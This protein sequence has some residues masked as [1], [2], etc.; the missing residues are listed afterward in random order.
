[1][2]RKIFV[3]R[4]KQLDSVRFF[5]IAII[6]LSHFEFLSNTIIGD[7]YFRYLKNPLMGVDYFFLLSGFG[8]FYTSQNKDFGIKFKDN[9][10][11]AIGKI[12]KIYGLYV[13]SLLISIPYNVF[14]T[15][16]G[17]NEVCWFLST[18][19]ICYIFVPPVI[20]FLK[21]YVNTKR[22]AFISLIINSVLIILIYSLFVK[23]ESSIVIKGINIIDDLSYGSPYFRI[24]YLIQGLNIA[25]LY[26]LVKHKF[27]NANMNIFECILFGFIILYIIFR[28]TLKINIYILKSLDIL[29]VTL[30]LFFTAINEG[31]ITKKLSNAR[32]LSYLGAEYGM[33]VYL[34]HY[35]IRMLIPAVLNNFKFQ[36][37]ENYNFIILIFLILFFTM[38]LSY[39]V[40][41]MGEKIGRINNYSKL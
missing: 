6:V 19:F 9:I 25:N 1:M 35:P 12:K 4:L 20:Q 5:A 8:L 41:M 26:I 40:K 2:E 23:I 14:F 39:I 11:F 31:I 21:T 28:N 36:L 33:Y 7:F 29:F 15:N 18:L 38:G 30:L 32:V 34:L 16:S 10:L 37:F 13:F 22:R 24:F 17:I 27:E 3:P